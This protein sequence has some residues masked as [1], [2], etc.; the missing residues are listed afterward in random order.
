[1]LRGEKATLASKWYRAV[2]AMSK[3][4]PVS[5]IPI[6]IGG[7]GENKTL[8]MVAFHGRQPWARRIHHQHGPERVHRGT[9]TTP[10]RN[11]LPHHQRLI[12]H[13]NVADLFCHTPV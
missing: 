10:W 5:K 6:M 4:A 11:L 1:M 7:A 13:P 3:P 9:R 2:E 8:Q 12:Q